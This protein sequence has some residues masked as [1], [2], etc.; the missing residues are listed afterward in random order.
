LLNR[1]EYRVRWRPVTA[2]GSAAW[3][4]GE[5][6]V[7][8]G[9]ASS[10]FGDGS[11]T[12][13]GLTASAPFEVEVWAV[14]A[15]TRSGVEIVVPGERASV[16]ATPLFDSTAAL[17]VAGGDGAALGLELLEVVTSGGDTVA[18]AD[19]DAAT[20]EVVRFVY[21]AP[22][23]LAT[24]EVTVTVT[25][26]QAGA[27]VTVNGDAV[28]S[29][30]A[31]APL[32]TDAG[33]GGAFEVV[34]TAPDAS[35]TGYRIELARPPGPVA[36]LAATPGYGTLALTW[37]AP[38]FAGTRTAGGEYRVRLRPATD[39][40]SAAWQPSASGEA[41]AV[42]GAFA[43]GA[44]TISGLD[45]GVAYEV[46]VWA[47]NRGGA[48]VAATVRA[49]P[50]SDDATLTALTVATGDGAAIALTLDR[51]ILRDDTRV[52]AALYDPAA[53][54]DVRRFVYTAAVPA[55]V[56]GVRV[57][58]TAAD[59][60][61]TLVTAGAPAVS[62]T[63][64]ALLDVAPDRRLRVDVDVTATGGTRTTY[65]ILLDRP[66]G[67]VRDLAVAAGFG[68]LALSWSPPVFAGTVA[69]GLS[70]QVRWRSA[71]PTRRRWPC[72]STMSMP[73]ANGRA[74]PARPLRWSR[75]P[76]TTARAT[77]WTAATRRATPRAT[78]GGSFNACTDALFLP[79]GR[80]AVR[81]LKE[82]LEQ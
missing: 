26:A 42:S 3:L 32:A 23:P 78:T 39:D 54:G 14:S 19:Y 48:G 71:A 41:V 79:P 8:A 66:P 47:A 27:T 25:P 46:Q 65:R 70:Y 33:K 64:S 68:S 7:V 18:A 4:P 29:G 51:V 75:P 56:S 10:V 20:H 55:G 36:N 13:E 67:Q 76:R 82:I 28:R 81:T 43:A 61:A 59:A 5:A 16:T 62:G 21:L 72:T 12:V 35:T 63:P 60:G 44:H 40:G 37:D 49:T 38:A 57:T 45:A 69:E 73:I 22:V 17:A 24:T 1:G 52:P 77:G 31:S 6:G 74:R 80:P 2:D 58:A 11:Y 9:D 34:V 50:L 30:E 15:A 53:A